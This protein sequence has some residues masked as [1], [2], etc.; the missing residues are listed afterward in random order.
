MQL[1]Q[2][3]AEM[4]GIAAHLGS[5]TEGTSAVAPVA[6]SGGYIAVVGSPGQLGQTRQHSSEVVSGVAVGAGSAGESYI[7]LQSLAGV[8]VEEVRMR[9]LCRKV[10]APLEGQ[11]LEGQPPVAGM[12]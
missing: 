7:P 2:L 4:G 6:P 10:G 12:P 1:T 8:L 5:P 3:V 11:P 9:D